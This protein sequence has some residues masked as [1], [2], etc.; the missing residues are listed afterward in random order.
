MG[1]ILPFN[2]NVGMHILR[3]KTKYKTG[4][5]LLFNGSIPR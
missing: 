5:A 1:E 3:E 4:N 2:A